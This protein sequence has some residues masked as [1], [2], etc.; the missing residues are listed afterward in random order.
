MR[1][2]WLSGSVFVALNVIA[3]FHAYKFTHFS[4]DSEKRT[5]SPSQLNFTQK[6]GTILVGV[7]NPRP[8]NRSLPKYPFKELEVNGDSKISCWY[9]SSE[10]AKGTVLMFHGYCSEKSSM[11]EKAY[12][13]RSL[14]YSTVLIDFMGSGGSEGCETTIGY[15]EARQ[16][17][18]CYNRM[19]RESSL[20][21]YLYGSSMGAVAILKAVS[22]SSIEPKG[23]ILECPFGNMYETV[24]KRF[25]NMGLPAFPMAGLLTFWGGTL[26]GFWAFGHNPEEYAENVYIPTLMMYGAKDDKVSM[27]EINSIYSKIKNRKK[28]IVLDGVGHEDYYS[29]A[30]EKWTKGVGTFLE[31]N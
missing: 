1:L 14:G 4:N 6:L 7:S 8:K 5:G 17:Q 16:V 19:N 15:K 18:L 23:L 31:D 24:A 21:I 10:S 27:D 12:Y 28:L 29:K 11:L 25:D 22:E 30:R 2:F 26:N 20:P 13:F 9:M 3:I